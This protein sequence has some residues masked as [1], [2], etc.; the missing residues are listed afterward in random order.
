[1]ESWQAFAT[2]IHPSSKLAVIRLDHSKAIAI[3]VA[4]IISIVCTY[5]SNF[6]FHGDVILDPSDASMCFRRRWFACQR[7]LVSKDR[8]ALNET[9]AESPVATR[10][11]ADLCL[12]LV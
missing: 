5:I 2:F 9:G 11:P 1:M 8:D 12:D 6:V 3:Q 10:S 7:H 4:R